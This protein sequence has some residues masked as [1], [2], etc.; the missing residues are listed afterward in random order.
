LCRNIDANSATS[1]A[2]RIA[3]IERWIAAQKGG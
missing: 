1:D 3:K 2:R